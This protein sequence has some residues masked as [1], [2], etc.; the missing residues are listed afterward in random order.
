MDQGLYFW[1]IYHLSAVSFYDLGTVIRFPY[2]IPWMIQIM[3]W[4]HHGP[5]QKFLL[6]RCLSS[7]L[8]VESA[9][10]YLNLAKVIQIFQSG[11]VCRRKGKY[12]IHFSSHE[13]PGLEKGIIA[14][15]KF[16]DFRGPIAT[17]S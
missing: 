9:C 8:A 6:L 14:R 15:T 1:G 5:I 10:T 11:L 7:H 4:H 2:L 13:T 16:L 17:S 12:L 3:F